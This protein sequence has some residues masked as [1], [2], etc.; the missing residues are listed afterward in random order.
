[1]EVNEYEKD[2][3]REKYDKVNGPRPDRFSLYWLYSVFIFS[4]YIKIYKIIS[5]VFLVGV[6]I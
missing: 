2:G 1:M 5:V 4:V 6:T 3:D